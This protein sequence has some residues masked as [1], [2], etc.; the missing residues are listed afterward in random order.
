MRRRDAM[1]PSSSDFMG[2]LLDPVH[3]L[4][5]LVLMGLGSDGHTASLFHGT[6]ALD[7]RERWVVGVEKAGLAPFVPGVRLTFPALAST[8][9]MLFLVS[10]EDKRDILARVFA[11][12]DLPAARAHSDSELAWLIDRAAS[13]Q[14]K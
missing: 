4:F 14:A 3:P 12:E 10:G 13:P 1:K 2:E 9:E 11:G 5:D 6:A 8:G 7:E